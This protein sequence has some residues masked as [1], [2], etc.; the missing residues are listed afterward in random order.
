MEEG[1]KDRGG[2]EEEAENS[3]SPPLSF[4][5][6]G[7]GSPA[8]DAAMPKATRPPREADNKMV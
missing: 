6:G 1:C 7:L 2:S 8:L 4:F 3:G 5:N